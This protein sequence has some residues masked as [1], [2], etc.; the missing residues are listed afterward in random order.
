M[1]YRLEMMEIISPDVSD[2]PLTDQSSAG[3]NW[4]IL[5]RGRQIGAFLV[6]SQMIE[7]RELKPHDQR[8]SEEH[9]CIFVPSCLAVS[10]EV[11]GVEGAGMG[12]EHQCI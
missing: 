3:E 8:V 10:Q 9:A 12:T 4:L 1:F 11:G 2:L 6:I 5:I 7:G